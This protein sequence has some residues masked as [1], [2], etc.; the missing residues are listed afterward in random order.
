MPVPALRLLS[1]ELTG[2]LVVLQKSKRGLAW[3]SLFSCLGSRCHGVLSLRGP[4]RR[5]AR[6]S[7]AHVSLDR[8]LAFF[9]GDITAPVVL[10]VTPLHHFIHVRVVATPAAHEVTAVAAV[11]GFVALPGRKRSR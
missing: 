6:A 5:G 4:R 8:L 3:E 9:A 11:G 7:L 1:G 2:P 10:A